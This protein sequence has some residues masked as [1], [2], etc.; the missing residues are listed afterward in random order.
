MIKPWHGDGPVMPELASSR[1]RRGG[2]RR[3][4]PGLKAPRLLAQELGDSSIC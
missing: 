2:E 4:A 3:E 1:G